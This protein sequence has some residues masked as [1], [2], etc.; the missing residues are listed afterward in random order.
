[1]ISYDK[2]LVA[3]GDI[4]ILLRYVDAGVFKHD[5]QTSFG[6]G[7]NLVVGSG[8][9]LNRFRLNPFVQSRSQVIDP[10]LTTCSE[11]WKS[12]GLLIWNSK[13]KETTSK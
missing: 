12:Q 11:S 13:P 9:K 5:I 6:R 10:G 1:M 3:G 7:L 8:W 4:G 2:A